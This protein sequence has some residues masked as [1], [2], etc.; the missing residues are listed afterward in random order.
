MAAFDNA[1]I[2]KMFLIGVLGVTP[3]K[4]TTAEGEMIPLPWQNG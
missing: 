2:R 1:A 3:V 4:V